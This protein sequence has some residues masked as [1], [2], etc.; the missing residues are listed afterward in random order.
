MDDQFAFQLLCNDWIPHINEVHARQD[1]NSDHG[2]ILFTK[3]QS[4]QHLHFIIN[5]IKHVYGKSKI[6][7][8]E[9]G[10]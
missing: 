7:R 9:L 4:N 3:N 1:L 10:I 8:E 5:I 6:E 2:L